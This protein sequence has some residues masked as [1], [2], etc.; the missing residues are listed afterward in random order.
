MTIGVT[1]LI[2]VLSVMNGFH[3]EM[4]RRVGTLLPQGHIYLERA[5][6]DYAELSAA[7]S[8]DPNI[9][10]FSPAIEEF[11]LLG[12]G[13]R[14]KMVRVFGIDPARDHEAE[15]LRNSVV[16]GAIDALQAQSFGIAVGD[17]TARQLGLFIDDEVELV[18][19]RFNATPA[20]VFPRSRVVTIE[21]IFSSGSPLDN[22]LAFMYL[23]DL[24]R[25]AAL[26][27]DSAE[28]LRVSSVAN[29]D[30]LFLQQLQNRVDQLPGNYRVESG[31]AGLETLFNAMQM[32][33][34]VVSIMLCAIVL[35]A[36]FN[37]VSGL[38]LMVAD[39]RADI[40][41]IRTCGASGAD[42]MKI[43]VT[44]GMVIGLSGI[45]LGGLLGTL[46]A[47]N[48]GEII[49]FAQQI[50]SSRLLDPSV[51]YIV[52]MP[53]E[54]HLQ[55]FIFIVTTALAITFLATLFPAWRASQISPV[56]ALS[57]QH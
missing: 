36:A 42:V 2:I 45:V 54:W 17:I 11:A 38:T 35:V 43:F 13:D 51:F 40:A 33:K 22:E 56:E 10:A 50:T 15:Q 49:E 14:S 26:P 16:A 5:S 9:A 31:A 46:V 3:S 27:R 37:I 28:L 18:L 6:A 23:G 52:E 19:P 24:G 32:E 39:K 12:A 34:I 30:G 55:D 7:L 25:L 29:D 53:S 4:Q 48:L 21:A 41:I 1:A 44:Q 57:Y 47:M 20:G 8:G